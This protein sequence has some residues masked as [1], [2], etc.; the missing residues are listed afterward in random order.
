MGDGRHR[1]TC[2]RR[3]LPRDRIR[4]P[5]SLSARRRGRIGPAGFRGRLDPA[6]EI[7]RLDPARPVPHHVNRSEEP[8]P[9]ATNPSHTTEP[10]QP[11]VPMPT[12]HG[13]THRPAPPPA[14][15]HPASDT[16]HPS[17]SSRPTCRS[18]AQPDPPHPALHPC[19]DHAST[20]AGLHRAPPTTC[21]KSA[22]SSVNRAR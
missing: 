7:P 8:P 11:S 12:A 2:V 19:H 5:G 17:R 10:S 3:R 1:I 15:S 9:S 14:R 21:R 6:T 18:S 20:L 13:R 4:G 22:V 16:A